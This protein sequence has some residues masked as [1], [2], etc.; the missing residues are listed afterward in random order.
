MPLAAHADPY[1]PP[2]TAVAPGTRGAFGLRK[3]LLET[4]PA[5]VGAPARS[6]G[7]SPSTSELAHAPRTFCWKS[8]RAGPRGAARM[9]EVPASWE[10]RS[11]VSESLERKRGLRCLR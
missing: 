2:A 3:D 10:L 1:E 8:P 11:T 9:A 7:F 4:L 5:G 6:R